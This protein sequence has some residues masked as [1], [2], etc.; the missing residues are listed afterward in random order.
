MIVCNMK[1][2]CDAAT[3]NNDKG[4]Q[5]VCLPTFKVMF[6]SQEQ[7]WLQRIASEFKLA[8][9]QSA[10]YRSTVLRTTDVHR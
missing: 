9:M 7:R 5:L 2:H 6:A 4:I 1:R 10:G 3:V 8:N